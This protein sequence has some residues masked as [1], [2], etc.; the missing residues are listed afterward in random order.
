MGSGQIIILI[1]YIMSAGSSFTN[2]VTDGNVRQNAQTFNP[3]LYSKVGA[4]TGYPGPNNGIEAA[5]GKLGGKI[6]PM[7]GGMRKPAPGPNYYSFVD[8]PDVEKGVFH[9]NYAPIKVCNNNQ[10]GGMRKTKRGMRKTKRG[11]RKTKR[12]M[13]IAKQGMR[14][15][16]QSMRNAKMGMKK[17]KLGMRR[18]K[19]GLRRTKKGMRKT[20]K[21]TMRKSR[22]ISLSKLEDVRDLFKMSGGAPAPL[23]PAALAPATVPAGSTSNGYHQY[24]G[25]QPHTNVYGLKGGLEPAENA[26]ANP[27][28]IKVTNQCASSK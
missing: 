23:N 22:R 25:N 1:I 16:K 10:C 19:K 28:P 12:G 13:R 20:L 18:T 11:M 9:K 8:T 15:A 21:N 6:V 24:M 2:F 7:K 14:N 26:L 4:I 5:A 27:I 17:M 3:D